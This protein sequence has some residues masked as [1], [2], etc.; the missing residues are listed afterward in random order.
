MDYKRIY[1]QLIER[2]KTRTLEGYKEK[3][4]I[5][6]KCL[7]GNNSKENLVELT[8]REHFLCH[9]LLI[10]IYPRN[11]ELIYA[12]SM[13]SHIKNRKEFQYG[14]FISSR[15]YNIIRLKKSQIQKEQWLE[16]RIKLGLIINEI[17]INNFIE[18]YPDINL[19]KNNKHCVNYCYNKNLDIENIIC[20]CGKG[21]KRL[22]NY[23][24]GYK[25][26]CSQKCANYYNKNKSLKT[27]ENNNLW[28]NSKKRLRKKEIKNLTIEEIENIRRNRIGDS[29][30]GKN[31][32]GNSNAKNIN[33]YDLSGNFIREWPS[34]RQAGLN[35]SNTQGE[36]I[37]KCLKG[38][39]KT[40]YNF[41]WKY[42]YN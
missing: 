37:R 27:K 41:K 2:A 22:E 38:M 12:V 6:P 32:K 33:Q 14:V 34:I 40:A 39:Q 36:P 3:H 7:G 20:I 11:I 42:K 1:N 28:D 15:L 18:L 25:K 35:I 26:F 30:R 13:M 4:H 5:I 9:L 21:I 8:A 23:T 16:K 19:T 24:K 10:E 17:Y 31:K 29:Q